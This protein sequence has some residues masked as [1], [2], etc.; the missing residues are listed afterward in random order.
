MDKNRNLLTV[1]RENGKEITY[2]PKRLRG[3]NVYQREERQFAKGDRI[4]FTAPFKAANIA[5][6]ELARIERIYSQGNL[7]LRLE[8]GKTTQF[9]LRELSRRSSPGGFACWNGPEAS[10][11]QPTTENATSLAFETG[12]PAPRRAAHATER[13]SALPN[14]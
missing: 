2:D 12:R 13:S 11:T 3:V 14:Q 10:G 5:N 9:N 4:Q 1:R 8:S 6:R 7:R